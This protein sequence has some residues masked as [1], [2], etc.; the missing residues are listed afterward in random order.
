MSFMV[1]VY[2]SCEIRMTQFCPNSTIYMV[3]IMVLLLQ[4]IL[5][6]ERIKRNYGN[7]FS[8]ICYLRPDWD[9]F[10]EIEIKDW[11]LMAVNW[12]QTGIRNEMTIV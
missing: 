6:G 9:K 3:V 12:I 8:N 10:V 4:T 2:S 7:N 5:T 11:L 1:G